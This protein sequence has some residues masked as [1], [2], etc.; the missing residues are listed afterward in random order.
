MESNYKKFAVA[1]IVIILLSLLLG[2]SGLFFGST[3]TADD[4]IIPAEGFFYAIPTIF[5][6]TYTPVGNNCLVEVTGYLQFFGTLSG[7]APGT[8]RALVFAP[9]ELVVDSAPGDYADVF[10]SKLEYEGTVDGDTVTTANITYQ[11]I[12]AEGGDIIA[13]MI[14]SNGLKGVLKVEARVLDIGYYN[15]FINVKGSDGE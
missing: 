5:P 12:T 3:A 9:C 6:F 2:G 7:I 13:K 10:M 15:G 8:T 4:N 1:S 11:G 14:L